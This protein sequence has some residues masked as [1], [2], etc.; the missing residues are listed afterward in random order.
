MGEVNFIA[1]KVAVIDGR[2]MIYVSLM[3]PQCCSDR[4]KNVFKTEFLLFL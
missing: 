1:Q 4:A 3:F 2:N